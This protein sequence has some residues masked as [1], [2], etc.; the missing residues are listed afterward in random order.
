MQE[1]GSVGISAAEREL[2]ATLVNVADAIR[3]MSE[4]DGVALAVSGDLNDGVP[5]R[6]ASCTTAETRVFLLDALEKASQVSPGAR[7]FNGSKLAELPS[8]LARDEEILVTLHDCF[9]DL[10]AV[11]GMRGSALNFHLTVLFRGFDHLS[12]TRR[13][14]CEQGF[15]LLSAMMS[16][17]RERCMAE[18]ER[19]TTFQEVLRYR[20]RAELDG[21]TLVENAASFKSIA[22]KRVARCQGELALV[23]IDLDDFKSIND[24]YGHQ[25]GDTYLKAIGRSLGGL[26]ALDAVVGRIGGDEF[27]LLMEAARITDSYL[28]IILHQ[29]SAK[30]QRD[31][32]NLK[33][34]GLG[35]MSMGVSVFGRHGTTF[36]DLF[37][38]ADAALYAIKADGRN[39]VAIF[40]EAEHGQYDRYSL[41]QRFDQALERNE[42]VPF[43][44]PIISFK[45]GK[46]TGFEMLARWNDKEQGLLAPASFS[47]IFSDHVHAEKLTRIVALRGMAMLAE[48]REQGR[49]AHATLNLNV[50]HFDLMR[51]EFVFDLQEWLGNFDMDW[52]CLKIEVTEQ[53]MLGDMEG[54][55]FRTLSEI[56]TRGAQVALDDFGT[57]YGGLQHLS[58]WPVDVIKIDRSF[59]SAM[60]NTERGRA[61]VNGLCRIALD[62]GLDVVAEGVETAETQNILMDMGCGF[63]QGYLFGK[64]VPAADTLAVWDRINAQSAPQA[65]AANPRGDLRAKIRASRA[66][67][68]GDTELSETNYLRCGGTK[69]S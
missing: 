42:I 4:A 26:S 22:E 61:V 65:Q 62:L 27:A 5:L 31:L 2:R 21:L 55:V 57:G 49:M 30:V 35:K 23:L 51:P 38:R 7:M 29:I 45:T 59:V 39:G 19:E 64:P 33:K 9:S 63:G 17:W 18:A 28:Q 34:P 68:A 10:P 69:T 46:C 3:G 11:C 8:L 60:E 54:Q 47:G 32:T 58:S 48:A 12:E 56:R 25:F 15:A 41:G 13:V 67:D 44:Q 6:V 66:G 24:I 1:L 53:T 52:G 14:A 20:R 16:Q 37:Q 50:T 40:D 43:F 36:E